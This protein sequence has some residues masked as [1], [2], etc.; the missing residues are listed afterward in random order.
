MSDGRAGRPRKSSSQH[1]A[2][3][4]DAV[5]VPRYSAHFARL[6]L[7]D[8]PSDARTV[9]DVGCATG[10][11]SFQ[12]LAR[13]GRTG[14]VIAIDRDEG[15]VDLARRRGWDEIGK[16]LFFKVEAVEQLSFGDGVFDAV[17][18]NLADE[19]L[20]APRALQELRRVLAPGG[21]L[22]LTTPL[23][24]T[25]AEVLDMFREI[26]VRDA[27]AE[28]AQRIAAHAAEAPTR[29]ALAAT[30]AEAGFEEVSVREDPFRLSYRNA[31]ELFA[32]RL[33]HLVGL[34][35]WR[36][37]LEGDAQRLEEAQRALDT[38]HA[39][40]PLSLTVRAACV[41]ARIS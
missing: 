9:L 16:R 21:R 22:F 33:V 23:R 18:G 10:H 31:A 4:V 8:V 27:D 25:F 38:Y 7:A 15:L 5:V 19:W 41:S 35:D 24:G 32:D 2:Q 17:V 12:I 3:L 29:D 40:G 39:G 36:A 11:V 13:L 14:R 34:P 28:L 30:V 26:A 1:D 20:L 6:F 37:L